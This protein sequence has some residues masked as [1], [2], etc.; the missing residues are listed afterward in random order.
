[1]EKKDKVNRKGF[2]TVTLSAMAGISMFPL[3]YLT[4]AGRVEGHGMNPHPDRLH[5]KDP[6]PETI[7]I[8]LAQLRR[9][10]DIP[11]STEKVVEVIEECSN[12]GVELVCFS[13]TY[14][15]GL[16][17]G[18]NDAFLGEPDQPALKKAREDIR[19]ACRENKVAAI[20]GM[21]WVTPEGLLN[22]AFVISEEGE[23]LGHQTKNQLTPGGEERNYV[24][25]DTRRLFTVKGVPIG[26]VICHEGWRYPETVR[27]AAVRGAKIVFQPQVTGG[28]QPD[29]NI[30]ISTNWGERYYDLAMILR[31]KENSIYFASVNEAQ[32]RQNS[33]TALI[34]PDGNLVEKLPQHVDALMIRDLDIS[35]ATGFYANRYRPELYNEASG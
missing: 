23:I 31:S 22:L 11:A 33:S 18:S 6:L 9:G 3:N 4:G 32:N 13:E 5:I 25:E 26:I 8:G 24:P 7:R 10:K 16:R 19:T 14:L 30:N 28:R 21:E 17:G 20:I 12:K 1:M 34:D 15:P 2:L 35:A 27:W 29:R